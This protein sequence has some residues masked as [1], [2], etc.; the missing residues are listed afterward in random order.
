MEEWEQAGAGGALALVRTAETGWGSHAVEAELL[1]SYSFIWCG[2][3]RQ[4]ERLFTVDIGCLPKHEI[5][6]FCWR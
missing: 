5:L 3:V 6:T 2:T 4:R 1:V